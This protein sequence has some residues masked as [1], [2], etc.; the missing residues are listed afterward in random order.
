M[1]NLILLIL[2]LFSVHT[3]EAQKKKAKVLPKPVKTISAQ[4]LKQFKV[5]STPA[6]EPIFNSNKIY[7]ITNSKSLLCYNLDGKLIWK[8]ES[9]A[10]ISTKP[11]VNQDVVVLTTDNGEII[12]LNS[13]L[14]EQINSLSL[15]TNVTAPPI[16]FDYMGKRELIIPKETNSKAAVLIGNG[17]GELICLDLETLQEYWKKDYLKD[18]IK[19]VAIGFNNKAIVQVADGFLYN[20][21]INNGL[22]FWRWKEKET[23]DFSN[24]QLVFNDNL[25]FTS[26]KDSTFYVI[27]QML[28]LLKWKL[29]YD[30]AVGNISLSSNKNVHVLTSQSNLLVLA[31][32]NGKAVKTI[33][34]KNLI[35]DSKANVFNYG[36]NTFLVIE[37]KLFLLDNK[38]K[39]NLLLN[40]NGPFIISLIQITQD[41][42]LTADDKGGITILQLR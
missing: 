38:F 4:I 27:D 18:S 37:D 16:V 5:D 32:E 29:N 1:K 10:N 11:F 14:G 40:L 7:V 28:G 34:F 26:S 8:F 35:K 39:E 13:T 9:P 2:F 24:S 25:L 41:K 17:K 30:K 22:M 23:T 20:I 15:D 19:S 33:D 6:Q 31:A 21:D 3:I 42:Y 12:L 36:V